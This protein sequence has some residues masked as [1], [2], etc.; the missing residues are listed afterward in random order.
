MNDKRVSSF[1]QVARV[2]ATGGSVVTLFSG[3]LDSS[4]LLARLCRQDKLRVY[5]LYVDLHGGDDAEQA[6]AT[7]ARLGAEPVLID[8]ATVFADEFV[9]PAIPAQATYL[10]MHPVSSSLSRPLLAREAVG[11]ADRVAATLVL[12]TANRSQNSLRR[13]NTAITDLGYGDYFGSPYEN[14]AIGRDEKQAA[15]K[16][17]GFP[18]F[19]ERTQS[20]DT[21][22]WCREFES[23]FLEDPEWFPVPQSLYTWTTDQPPQDTD[24][25][26]LEFDKGRPIALDGRPTE[27]HEMIESLNIRVGRFGLGRYSGLEHIEGGEKVL[28]VREMPAAC[29]LLFAYRHLEAATVPAETMREKVSIEQLWTREAVEG[30]WFGA[31]RLAA[32][33]FIANVAER[34]AGRITIR[35]GG[36]G[37][38]ASSVYAP[39][40][41]Y[42]RDRDRWESETAA[43]GTETH[44]RRTP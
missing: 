5:A 24:E 1:S 29:L 4:Y 6:C 12:H 21:N 19:V 35:L 17:A 34:V 44:P 18:E 26:T 15:L 3:G 41:L 33:A 30:R 25:V 31:S 22:L 42:I 11:L 8:D 7:A 16:E 2:T 38:Q 28:E 14:D 43:P 9:A 27:L 13:L 39:R 32:Q 36:A 10:G 40:P 20:G 23:G 37:M